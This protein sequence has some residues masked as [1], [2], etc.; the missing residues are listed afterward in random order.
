MIRVAI[1]GFGRIGRIAFRQLLTS[2]DFL[3]VA[4]NS[5]SGNPEEFAYLTKYDTVH[6]TFHEDSISFDEE[7]LLLN[8]QNGT[9]KVKVFNY[10]DPEQL[11]WNE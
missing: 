11:P 3:V 6:G 2:P 7:N 10:D 1:N 5:R 8:G 9:V 4:I